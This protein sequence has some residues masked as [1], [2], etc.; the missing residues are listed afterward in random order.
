[1]LLI[2]GNIDMALFLYCFTLVYWTS[3]L[4]V[5]RI[6]LNQVNTI[7][8]NDEKICLLNTSSLITASGGKVGVLNAWLGSKKSNG[9]IA[10]N[11]R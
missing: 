5:Y 4:G 1:M 6:H 2:C 3:I 7:T 9:N 10:I 11:Y 8:D